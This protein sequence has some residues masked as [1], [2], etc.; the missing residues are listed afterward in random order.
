MKIRI[1]TNNI[2]IFCLAL[3]A[4]I[5]GICAVLAFLLLL[6]MLGIIFS[7]FEYITNL[8]IK[9]KHKLKRNKNEN[10]HDICKSN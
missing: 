3:I 4:Y 6:I 9:I 5:I 1:K 8:I 2:I 7:F 10:F